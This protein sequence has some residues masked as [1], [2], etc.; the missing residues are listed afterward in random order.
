MAY[1]S[2]A[3]SKNLIKTLEA[4]VIEVDSELSVYDVPYDAR[5]LGNLC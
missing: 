4:G 2:I 5:M 1:K 3:D